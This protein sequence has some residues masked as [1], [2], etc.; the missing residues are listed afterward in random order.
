MTRLAAEQDRQDK[1]KQ[2]FLSVA[3]IGFAASMVAAVAL[4]HRR[5]HKLAQQ[6]GENIQGNHVNWALRAFGLGTLYAIGLVGCT[7][8]G[9]NYYLQQKKDVRSLADLRQ[10]IGEY[11]GSKQG[12]TSLREILKVK[13]SEDRETLERADRLLSE[14]DKE[15]G[16]KKIKFAR[17][18]GLLEKDEEKNKLSIGARMRAAMGFGKDKKD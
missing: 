3:G 2:L 16:K 8:F 6:S 7:A 1:E 4:G 18:K 11:L 17:I 10:T 9:T 14:I 12:G 15:T 5:A 13:D